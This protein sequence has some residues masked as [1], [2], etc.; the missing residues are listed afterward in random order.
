MQVVLVLLTTLL[1][2]VEL[3][4]AQE[5]L[6]EAAPEVCVLQPF[7]LCVKRIQLLLGPEAQPQVLFKLQVLMETTLQPLA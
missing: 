6:E 5:L 1:W 7:Q 4:E 3:A 2:L